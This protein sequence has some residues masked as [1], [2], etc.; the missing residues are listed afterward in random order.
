MQKKIY[1]MSV[2]AVALLCMALVFLMVVAGCEVF[3]DYPTIQQYRMER[4]RIADILSDYSLPAF[5]L[6]RAGQLREL[7]VLQHKARPPVD[8]RDILFGDGDPEM[9]ELSERWRNE[10]DVVIL[11]NCICFFG[12]VFILATRSG[13][14]YTPTIRLGPAVADF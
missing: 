7:A 8:I 4:N 2:W 10:R 12:I 11:F 14:I 3:K 13:M 5:S 6:E 1:N 9:P